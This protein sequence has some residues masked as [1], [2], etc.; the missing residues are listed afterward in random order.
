MI[1][2]SSF[3]TLVMICCFK[4][5]KIIINC[6][7]LLLTCQ[8]SIEWPRLNQEQHALLHFRSVCR[9]LPVGSG[10][11]CRCLPVD[12]RGQVLVSW[13]LLAHL[14]SSLRWWIVAYL[15]LVVCGEALRGRHLADDLLEVA[16]F[17]VEGSLSLSELSVLLGGRLRCSVGPEGGLEWLGRYLAYH[18][19]I[20]FIPDYS[21]QVTDDDRRR[22]DYA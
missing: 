18:D 2:L 10:R 1:P 4:W 21:L 5:P 17:G 11:C 3:W 16:H 12:L 19:F 15:R 8:K 22:D 6:P 14:R 9:P 13:P 7:V 20:S